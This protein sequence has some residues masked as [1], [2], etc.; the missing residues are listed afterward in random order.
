[1]RNRDDPF[2]YKLLARGSN[3]KIRNFSSCAKSKLNIDDKEYFM[4]LAVRRLL[5][6]AIFGALVIPLTIQAAED[7]ERIVLLSVSDKGWADWQEKSFEGSTSYTL[8]DG[9]VT[10]VKAESNGT[11]SGMFLEKEINI[12]DYPVL[13]WSW[14]VDKGLVAHDE[15]TKAGDD[16]AARVY[17]VVSGGLFFWK[18]IAIN[19]VWS[20]NSSSDKAWPNAY[21]GDNAQMLALRGSDNRQGE[22]HFE[23]RNLRDDFQALFDRDIE[24]IDGIAIMTDTD[25]SGSS[26]VAIYGEMYLSRD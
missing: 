5:V 19:Y 21:A 23:S 18:T 26:A 8:A 12:K 17:V 22:W 11:A 1:V 20:S 2:I 16:Y 15:T 6:F 13:S 7:E 14:K 3:R 4:K 24:V 25:D 9:E 10:M